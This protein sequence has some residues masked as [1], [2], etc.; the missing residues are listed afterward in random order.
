M[1]IPWFSLP[2][3]SWDYIEPFPWLGA[4]L[5]GLFATRKNLYKIDIPKNKI[6]RMF[7]YLGKHSLVI[8]LIHQPILF[9]LVYGIKLIIH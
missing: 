2:H 6:T 5:F 4:S 3:Q 1:D 8:Y 9:S 7:T